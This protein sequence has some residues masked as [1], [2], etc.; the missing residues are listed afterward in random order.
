MYAA[1]N[2]RDGSGVP[3]AAF[4]LRSVRGRY[5]SSGIVAFERNCDGP[6]LQHVTVP[7]LNLG[8]EDEIDPVE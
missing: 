5:R 7:F 1:R 8:H 3:R 6:L 2:A 4:W